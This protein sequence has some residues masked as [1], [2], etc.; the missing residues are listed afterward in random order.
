[1]SDNLTKLA[2]MVAIEAPMR[3]KYPAYFALIT[4]QT[5]ESIRAE[6]ERQ[7]FDWRAAR[8]EYE[9]LMRERTKAGNERH[10]QDA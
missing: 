3:R 4:W 10:K 1:M 7:G 8:K 5:V 2:T 9:R 6:L